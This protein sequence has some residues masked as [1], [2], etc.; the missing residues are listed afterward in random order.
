M[1]YPRELI[2]RLKLWQFIV[3]EC[4]CELDAEDDGHVPL[5]GPGILL[6]IVEDTGGQGLCLDVAMEFRDYAERLG[7]CCHVSHLIPPHKMYPV[8]AD[9]EAR[10]SYQCAIEHG[11]GFH[12]VSVVPVE[13]GQWVFDFTAKQFGEHFPFPYIWFDPESA[14]LT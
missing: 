9:T 8:D 11:W 7:V 14:C 5:Q 12:S 3:H 1:E 13:G 6:D 2:D 4:F 10:I